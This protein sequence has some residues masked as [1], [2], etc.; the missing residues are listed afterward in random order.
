MSDGQVLIDS[1]LDTQ[2]VQKGADEIQGLFIKTAETAAKAANNIEK[3]FKN[4]NYKDA[5]EKLPASYQ[6][7][8]AKI[9]TIRAND[10]LSEK[11][12]AMQIAS[13]YRELGY[14]Q[15]EAL[16][17]AWDAMKSESETGSPHIIENL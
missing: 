14:N 9:E 16:A 3:A 2:G 5:F 6:S 17:R 12:R 13:V 4:T 8:Y 15:Q 1:K 11:Q 10:S 7:A